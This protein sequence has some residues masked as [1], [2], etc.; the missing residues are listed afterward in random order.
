MSATASDTAPLLSVEGLRAWFPIKRGVL[1]RTVGHVQ[2]VSGVDLTV[3]AGS[4]VALELSDFG[5][6]LETLGGVDRV[7]WPR[8]LFLGLSGSSPDFIVIFIRTVG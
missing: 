7:I 2:A 4:T 3:R 8:A 5:S 1:R 6:F